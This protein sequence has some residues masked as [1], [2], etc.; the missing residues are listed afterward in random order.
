MQSCCA[1]A[2]M[3]LITKHIFCYYELVLFIRRELDHLICAATSANKLLHSCL[4][5][6]ECS[7]FI[8]A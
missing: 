2:N 3:M 4:V 7:M 1:S 6:F 5:L 8:V